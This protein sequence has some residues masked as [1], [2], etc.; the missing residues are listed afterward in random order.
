[1]WTCSPD[2]K[3][4]LLLKDDQEELL[5]KN[6]YFDLIKIKNSILNPEPQKHSQLYL[7]CITGSNKRKLSLHKI[8]EPK[9]EY[10]MS[11]ALLQEDPR[12]SKEDLLI[13]RELEYYDL[14][15]SEIIAFL[16]IKTELSTNF[17]MI[18]KGSSI[19]ILDSDLKLKDT[20][21]FDD[22]KINAVVNT[23]HDGQYLFGLNSRYDLIAIDLN[24]LSKGIAI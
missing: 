12:V 6:S 18:A 14:R 9:T 20:S 11:E 23:I 1:M 15:S 17:A 16:E 19:M 21:V 24:L 4:S 8:N 7:V 10:E 5:D 2:L 22:C 13:T 3:F